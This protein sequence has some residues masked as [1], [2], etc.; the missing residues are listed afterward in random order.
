VKNALEPEWEA[1]FEPRSYGFRPGRGCHDAIEILYNALCGAGRARRGWVLDADLAGAFDRI[2]HHHLLSQLGTFPA[3]DEIQAWLS[4]GAMEQGEHTPTPEGTPQGG[5][6]S[7]LLLN[8]ALHG[9]EQA[10]GVRYR[11]RMDVVTARSSPILVR[12]ADDLVAV[13][14]SRE[15]AE[16]VKTRLQAWLQPRGLCFNEDKTRIVHVEEGFSFL[17]FD[18]R[19]FR[20]Q[21]GNKLIITPSRESVKRFRKRLKDE[22]IHYRG[23]NTATVIGNLN[24]IIR[25]WAAYYR[26]VV[27]TETFRSLD[28]YMWQLAYRWARHTHPNKSKSWIVS[29]YFGKFNRSRQDNWVFGD[30]D[31]GNHL[32]KFS[33]TPIVRHA[34]VRFRASPDDPTLAGYWA[35]RQHRRH[36]PPLP[37]STLKL[38]RA[39]KG[40]CGVCGD[41]LIDPGNEPQTTQ[42]WATWY[43]TTYRTIHT[44]QVIHPETGR[45]HWQLQ[46]A[47]CDRQPRRNNAQQPP[48]SPTRL[49]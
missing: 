46:H 14:H 38:Y 24:P 17:G 42:Q 28:W 20:A 44:R 30:R 2:D 23:Q 49:A 37:P 5:V 7:P 33:W 8:V 11:G 16:Q 34:P 45:Q 48:P 29:R 43:R 41:P 39:Q 12:Y 36:P 9:M 32:T 40:D 19:R 26:G 6:I 22:F 35:K 27:S 3:R 10:A 18:I 13:C 25:G 31:S 21:H 1:R 15:Q 47:N 4:A